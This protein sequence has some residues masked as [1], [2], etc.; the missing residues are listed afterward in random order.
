M[1]H[2]AQAYWKAGTQNPKQTFLLSLNTIRPNWEPHK[3]H[4]QQ[5][6]S[7]FI[8]FVSRCF[9]VRS[10][11]T[12]V[13]NRIKLLRMFQ[14]SLQIHFNKHFSEWNTK[15]TDRFACFAGKWNREQTSTVAHIDGL[16]GILCYVDNRSDVIRYK[17]GKVI[18]LQARCGPEGG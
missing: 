12:G 9:F 2:C 7:H 15:I 8:N 17:K 16:K 11:S 13:R 10:I 18:P 1:S 4:C 3:G 14:S 6:N 5:C